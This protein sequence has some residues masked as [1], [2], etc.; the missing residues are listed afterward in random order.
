MIWLDK[1]QKNMLTFTDDKCI[2]WL[3]AFGPC[4]YLLQTAYS[5]SQENGVWEGSE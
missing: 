5:G 1:L 3:P 2:I 4:F